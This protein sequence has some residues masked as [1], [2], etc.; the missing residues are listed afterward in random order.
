MINVDKAHELD[1]N[2]VAIADDSGNILFYLT[3]GSGVPSGSA[4]INSW[5]FD[6]DS[7]LMYYKYGALNTDWRQLR[8]ADITA[9]NQLTQ[10]VPLQTFLD[11]LSGGGGSGVSQTAVFGNGGNTSQNSYLPN[12]GVPSNIVGVPV[13]IT[14]AKI[15]NISIGNENIRTGNVLIQERFP[16]GAGT[17][18][19]IYTLSL[20]NQNYAFAGNLDIPITANAELAVFTEIS[21]KN[22]KVLLNI[23]GDSAT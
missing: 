13:N 20:T 6:K 18:T 10:T 15:R 22:V 4:P 23:N 1:E 19:T 16:P 3:S 9:V 11:T 7:Q 17:W 8:A 5:Y 2:G 12:S 14:N 21:L